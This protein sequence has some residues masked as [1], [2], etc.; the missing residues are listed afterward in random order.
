M[1][2][3]I[4]I[5]KNYPFVKNAQKRVEIGGIGTLKPTRA[6]VKAFNFVCFMLKIGALNQKV[7][8]D[9]FV[10]KIKSFLKNYTEQ[11]KIHYLYEMFNLDEKSNLEVS[12]SV[13]NKFKN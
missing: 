6:T 13:S 5:R 11:K 4:F 3:L 10:K 2:L 1:L 7:V 8:T 9:K 12:E